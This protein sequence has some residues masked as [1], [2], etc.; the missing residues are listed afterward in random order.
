[1]KDNKAITLITLAIT[2]IVI[3]ILT[4]VGINLAINGG[5]I[6]QSRNFADKLDEDEIIQKIKLAYLDLEKE[7]IYNTNLNQEQFLTSRL[8]NYFGTGKISNVSISSDKIAITIKIRGEDKKFILNKKTSEIEESNATILGE[9]ITVANYG[10]YLDLGKNI[11][12]TDATTDDWQ[13]IYIDTTNNKIYAILADYLPNS[14]NIAQASGLTQTNTYC[15]SGSSG[16]QDFLNKLKTSDWKENLLPSR[17]QNNSKISVEGAVSA[18]ILMASYN[19]K[20]GTN[21]NYTN[22]PYFRTNPQNNSSSIDPIYMPHAGSNPY[23]NC[24][25]YWTAS[26]YSGDNNNLWNINYNGNFRRNVTGNTNY[27]V[28]PVVILDSDVETTVTTINNTN[29]WSISD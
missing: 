24:Y 29:V 22:Q 14:T 10:D 1:M 4:I 8:E 18:E 17:L 19:E 25:G 3:M 28:R 7:R 21:L 15:V 6:G 11:V 5:I 27:G 9:E 23:S 2:I 26:P 16:R 12:G 13:I 20:Y